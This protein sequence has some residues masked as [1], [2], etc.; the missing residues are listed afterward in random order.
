MGNPS[1]PPPV[2]VPAPVGGAGGLGQKIED[3]LHRFVVRAMNSVKD[4]LAHVIRF[5]LQIFLEAL[6]P[7]LLDMYGPMLREVTGQAETPAS[8]KHAIDTALSGKY[9]A[10]AAV[11]MQL[12]M[13]A[14]SM[15]MGSLMNT[16][17]APLTYAINRKIFPGRLPASAAITAMQHFPDNLL[18][19]L[20]D[21]YDQGL[22]NTRIAVMREASTQ[23][24]GAGE[25]GQLFLRGKIT[26]DEMVKAM[27]ANGIQEASA[28]QYVDLLQVI[29]TP[30]DLIALAVKEAWDDNF[31]AQAGTDAEFPAEFAQWAAKQGLSGEWSK[32]YWRAHWQLPSTLQGFEMFHR[33]II[34][35]QELDKL[36]KALDISPFWRS[37]LRGITYNPYTRVDVR[38]L[39]N[40]NILTREQVKRNYLDLGYDD[41]HAENLTDFTVK[42]ATGTDAEATKTDVL[43]GYATGLLTKSEAI[44]WLTDLDYPKDLAEFYVAREDAKRENARRSKRVESIHKLYVGGDITTPEASTRLTGLGLT[45]NEIE[46]YLDDWKIERDSKTVKPS[47]TQLET[48][49]KQDIITEAD[50]RDGLSGAGWQDRYIAWLTSSVLKEKSDAANALAQQQRLEQE[51]LRTARSKSDYAVNKSALDT[52]IAEAGVAIAETQVALAD[53]TAQ[54][55]SDL[56]I[57]R[58]TTSI[59]VLQQ[60]AGKDLASLQSQ[61]DDSNT[62]AATLAENVNAENQ[63]IADL[64][65][66]LSQKIEATNA[67]VKSLTDAEA[68]AAARDELKAY[69]LNVNTLNARH[70]LTIAQIQG[71]IAANA[72]KITDLRA[73]QDKRK[74]QL[75]KELD[76]A[77]RVKSVTDLTAQFNTDSQT[78]RDTLNTLRQH[79]TDLNLQKAKLAQ[80]LQASLKGGG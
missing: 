77:A 38:R 73:Q 76:V 39:Y 68:I 9:E 49:L 16:I 69:A 46:T 3:T 20:S 36:L 72:T 21:L 8:L 34:T 51:R 23:R 67:L 29:P 47:P 71:D 33:G 12:G 18:L 63:A 75:A 25:L 41:Q 14:G 22:D 74:A 50:Y 66:Q 26:Q 60:N 55:Q 10:G 56:A 17:T 59:A 5:G 58:G 4:T 35:E 30:N 15:V 28:V 78:Y 53:L 31:A 61:I 2:T 54:Y 32:R 80:T 27:V 52:E 70:R 45:G 1:V 37:K 24:L 40:K 62:V 79:V 11:L 64:N 48:L 57:A 65:V 13:G 6:E 7:E 43:S 19:P 44:S 42:D